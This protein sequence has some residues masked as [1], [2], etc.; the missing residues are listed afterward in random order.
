M[1]HYVHKLIGNFVCLLFGAEQAV[2]YLYS[3][4]SD[5]F[6]VLGVISCIISINYLQILFSVHCLQVVVC[7]CID[8][9][10]FSMEEHLHC[11]EVCENPLPKK[12]AVGVVNAT[13]LLSLLDDIPCVYSVCMYV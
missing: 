2:V 6:F 10:R 7:T 11:D 12:K 5:H 8:L 3:Y 1:L 9:Q 4:I 13:F